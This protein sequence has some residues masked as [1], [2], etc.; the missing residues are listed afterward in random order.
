[1]V[2]LIHEK[3]AQTLSVPAML[4]AAGVPFDSYT[5]NGSIVAANYEL[6]WS[7]L[8]RYP[9]ASRTACRLSKKHLAP[10]VITQITFI[11]ASSQGPTPSST[12]TVVY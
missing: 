3:N 9:A 4:G 6:F 10:D 2:A 11:T 12:S 1:M 5:L 8:E 7:K